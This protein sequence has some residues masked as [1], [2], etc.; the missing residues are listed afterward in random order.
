MGSKHLENVKPSNGK[1][2]VTPF[3]DPEVYAQTTCLKPPGRAGSK[4]LH[5]DLVCQTASE[6]H[7]K[8]TEGTSKP[9]ECD[10]SQRG[11]KPP[12]RQLRCCESLR[13]L[14]SPHCRNVWG[15]EQ[16]GAECRQRGRR[17]HPTPVNAGRGPAFKTARQGGQPEG[18]P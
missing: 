4:P 15:E 5:Q 10:C 3:G 1:V 14:R 17:F 16:G 6:A 12:R 8:Q 18:A 13:P 9:C 11:T 7:S 2:L